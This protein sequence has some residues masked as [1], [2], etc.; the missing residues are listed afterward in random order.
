MWNPLKW[1][2]NR[3]K[4]QQ[5]LADLKT[6]ASVFG[7]LEQLEKSNLLSWSAKDRRLYVAEPLAL[8]ML[9]RGAVHWQRFL[10][11]TY[12]YLVNKLMKDA[13]DKYVRDEQRKAVSARVASGVKV[14]PGELDRIR[15]GVRESIEKDVIK[16]PAIEPFEFFVIADSPDG[17]K[18]A[19]ITFV[20][21]YNPDTEN[22]VM[23]SW[24]DV[25]AAIEATKN[26]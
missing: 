17:D 15:R 10:N 9:E 18:H 13:W 23:A 1:W 21:E 5:I 12:L 25:K 2:T 11:N 20:G 4:K 19:A 6:T 3:R 24:D 22:F 26:K 8:V 16:V 7:T 14:N